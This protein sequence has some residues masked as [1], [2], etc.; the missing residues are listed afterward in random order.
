MPKIKKP[1]IL[2][3]PKS[4]RHLREKMNKLTDNFKLSP[5]MSKKEKELLEKRL[6]ETKPYQ[7]PKS[8]PKKPKAPKKSPKNPMKKRN[9]M[10][11]GKSVLQK[12]KRSRGV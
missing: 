12:R 3:T 7:P 1:G 4:R 5:R 6:G 11:R 10:Y 9:L 2:E 8:K